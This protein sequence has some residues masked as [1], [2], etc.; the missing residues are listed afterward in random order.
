MKKIF[1]TGMALVV[2]L[3][4][5]T[6]SCHKDETNNNGNNNGNTENPS[7]GGSGDSGSGRVS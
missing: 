1:M 2:S 7:G 3:A 5:L 6:T 4:M